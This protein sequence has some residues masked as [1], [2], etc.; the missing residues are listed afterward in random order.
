[1][2]TD[3]PG[4]FPEPRDWFR[5][6]PMLVFLTELAEQAVSET[7]LPALPLIARDHLV[8]VASVADPEVR[9]WAL[10]TP[11]APGAAYPKAPAVAALADRRRTVARLRGLGAV[12]VDGPPGRLAPD[13]ADPRLEGQGHRGGPPPRAGPERPAQAPAAPFSWV[14][15]NSGRSSTPISAR[16]AG[17]PASRSITQMATASSAPWARSA[18][19]AADSTDAA[20]A[21]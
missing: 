19:Q 16:F 9:G 12:V 7:L 13:L 4:A 6:R 20:G 15:V 18:R 1:P 8:V 14:M 3:S 17:P 11:A 2:E 10:D 21:R 5:R